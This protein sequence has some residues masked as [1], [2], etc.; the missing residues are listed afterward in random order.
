MV[1]GIGKNMVRNGCCGQPS[2][3]SSSS[4]V[5]RTLNGSDDGPLIVDVPLLN[6]IARIPG[7][8]SFLDFRGLVEQVQLFMNEGDLLRCWLAKRIASL[9]RLC[10]MAVEAIFDPERPL[11]IT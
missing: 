10:R 3:E 7:V 11:A 9:W 1:V 8:K 5:G 6:G 2:L 4:I